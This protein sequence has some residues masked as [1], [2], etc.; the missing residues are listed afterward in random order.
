MS[1][2]RRYWTKNDSER[3]S[4]MRQQGDTTDSPRSDLPRRTPLGG[5]AEIPRRLWQAG[6][7][8]IDRLLGRQQSGKPLEPN[9]REQMEQA[10]GEDFE[11]VRLHDDA[12]AQQKAAELDAEAFTHGEDIYLGAGSLSVETAERKSLLAHELAHVVQ[13]RQAGGVTKPI[14]SHSGDRFEPAADASARQVTQGGQ[15]QIA[16]SG[17]PPAVQRQPRQG[18][19]AT[20]EEARAALEA[21]LR[22]AL[23]AQGG[24]SLRVT[25]EVRSAVTSLFA[26]DIGRLLSIDA[27]LSKLN[28]PGDPAEFA[29]EVARR[30]PEAIDRSRIE[31]L[32]RMSGQAPGQTSVIGRAQEVLERTAPGSPEREEEK[33]AERIAKGEAEPSRTRIP[34]REV[35]TPGLPTPEK[36]I[37]QIE[38]LGRRIRGEEEPTTIGPGSVDVL[39]LARVFGARR[40]ILLGPRTARPT[41]PE[42][43][44]YPEVE[45]A[46]Q[47]IAPNALLPPEARGTPQAD[48]FADAREV[49]RALARRL[50]VAQQ[51]GQ[52]T[53]DLHLGDNY[54]QV[55]DRT[56]M[57]SEIE[58]IVALIR[59]ALPHHASAIRF[60]DVYFGNRLVTRSVPRPSE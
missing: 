42:A 15:A 16:A 59:E 58:R 56:A 31:A 53:I 48:S 4:A 11:N 50:D 17:T 1:G 51:Q 29:R 5:L 30:L 34:A 33:E 38:Q 7:A 49:A 52:D 46:I 54:N 6:N 26:G 18:N 36:R 60:V 25:P 13:Q 14:V 10:F 37:E 24:R 44:T 20:R 55:R 3:G 12:A 47:Q 35:A 8:A 39:H 9:I 21:F 41:P 23:Q 32:N 2:D 45:R 57:I 19:R 28:L 43:R 27:W 22:R 40:E